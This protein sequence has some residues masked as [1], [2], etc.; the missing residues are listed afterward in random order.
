MRDGIKKTSNGY[1]QKMQAI[2]KPPE[3][4]LLILEQ[5]V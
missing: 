1:K 5:A 3:A 4:M 2:K